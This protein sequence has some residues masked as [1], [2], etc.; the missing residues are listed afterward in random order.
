MKEDVKEE[1]EGEVEEKQEAEENR[2]V[3]EDMEME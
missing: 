3:K 1:V 2:T